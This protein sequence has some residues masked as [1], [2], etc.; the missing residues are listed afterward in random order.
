MATALL[1]E[2][3]IARQAQYVW[4]CLTGYPLNDLHVWRQSYIDDRYH[5]RSNACCDEV[6]SDLT[7]NELS[8]TLD[9]LARR[10]LFPVLGV[11]ATRNGLNPE[12]Q[13]AGLLVGASLD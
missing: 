2:T 8:A 5:F 6:M 4:A 12:A 7:V 10:I 3:M 1:S 11:L 9:D 13:Y